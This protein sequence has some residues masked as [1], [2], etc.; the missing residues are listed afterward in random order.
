MEMSDWSTK[1]AAYTPKIKELRKE[2]K[3][4]NFIKERTLSYE[5]QN[6]ELEQNKSKGKRER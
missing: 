4:C 2:I 3:T 5:K 1:A 6:Q